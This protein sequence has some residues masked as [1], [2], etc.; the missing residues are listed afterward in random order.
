MEGLTADTESPKGGTV[1]MDPDTGEPTGL[2]K[3]TAAGKWAWK[4]FPVI[5]AEQ[6]KEGL[7]GT[8]AYL[9]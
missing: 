9:S 2:V 6:N 7:Q 1:V 8:I 4:H 3:E 5:S